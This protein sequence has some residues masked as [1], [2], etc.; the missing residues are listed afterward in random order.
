MKPIRETFLS[1][2][3]WNLATLNVS[4]RVQCFFEKFRKI[5][6]QGL[7]DDTDRLGILNQLTN[8]LV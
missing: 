3:D 4:S 7:Q 8:V 2:E 6:F 5:T 1:S